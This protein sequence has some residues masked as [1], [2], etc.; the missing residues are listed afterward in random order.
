VR[1]F[2]AGR[3]VIERRTNHI[4]DMQAEAEDYAEGR[5]VAL[6]LGWRTGLGVPLLRAGEAIGVILLRRREVRPFTHKQIE[7]LKTFADQAVIAIE[8]TRLSRRCKREPASLPT[9]SRTL[10]SQVSTSRSSSPT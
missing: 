7:L 3:A 8:N 5:E 9:P 1:G 10:R 2:I 6:R 4:A